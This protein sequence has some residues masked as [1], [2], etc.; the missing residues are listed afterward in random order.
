MTASKLI[1]VA[2]GLAV[3]ALA[4]TLVNDLNLGLPKAP[5]G[6]L[7]LL[8]AIAG[9]VVALRAGSVV[10]SGSLLAKGVI[11]TAVAAV[12]TETGARTGV[13]FGVIVLA[14]GIILTVITM[15]TRGKKGLPVQ[16][17]TT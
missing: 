16:P 2:Q 10:V 13:V 4:S 3:L 11:D 8:L 15:R 17:V 6:I 12:S 1:P 14:L 9:F 7:S 5:V